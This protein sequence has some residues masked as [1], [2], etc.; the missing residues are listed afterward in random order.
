MKRRTFLRTTAGISAFGGVA[1][2]G[3]FPARD[4]PDVATLLALEIPK[5]T[6]LQRIERAQKLMAENNFNLLIATP[7]TTFTYFVGY[8][9]GRSERLIALLIP[10]EGKPAIVS[11]SFERERIVRRSVI[12]EIAT[13]EEHENPYKLCGTVAS[14]MKANNGKVGVEPT[15]NYQDFLRLQAALPAAKVVDGSPVFDELRMTKTA[16]ELDA[17]QKAIDITVASIGATHEQLK[18]GMTEVEVSRIL[19]GEM[20]KRGSQGGG[21]VQFGPNS[22]LPHGGPGGAKLSKGTVVLIDAGCRIDGYT[23]DVTRTIFWGAEMP[24]KYREVFNTV[25][26]AQQ[27]AASIAKAGV[28]CQELDRAARRVIEKAGYGK[29]FTHRVGHGMGMD[30]HEH[31]YMVEGNSLKLKLGYV[32]TIEPGI[33]IPDEFG[34]R[35][36]DDFVLTDG[37]AKQMAQRVSKV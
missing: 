5:P 36:E 7:G 4:W 30:G 34:V 20:S 28:E 18:E 29:Y 26:D 15:T 6:L 21:L 37:G 2:A 10:R 22:A 32:F 1:L 16:E 3:A 11:P 19:S 25:F 14:S 17:I 27:A 35:I 33:Y 12:S 13:W 24:A 23:S 9:P 8:N 31:P